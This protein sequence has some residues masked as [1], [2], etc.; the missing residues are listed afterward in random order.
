MKTTK[1]A[2]AA[3]LALMVAGCATQPAHG[4]RPA[5]HDVSWGPGWARIGHAAVH[6]AL[7]PATW[8]PAVGAGLLQIGHADEDV[9]DWASDHTPVFGSRHGAR[10]ASNVFLGSA[11]A[12]DLATTLAQPARNGH[13]TNEQIGRLGVAVG[14][15][16][17]SEGVVQ[18][19]KHG[20]DRERP[21]GSDHDSFP[22]G[23]AAVASTADTMSR[24]NAE[25]LPI[26]WPLRLTIQ[27]AA[28]TLDVA[29][30]YARVAAE[31]HYP[32]DVLA[33][34][35]LGHFVGALASQAFLGDDGAAWAPQVS[36]SRHGGALAWSRTF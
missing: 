10:T 1:P 3:A 23:H 27:G 28:T 13:R 36:L 22:S 16:G 31:K 19:L 2:A 29:T 6:A 30:G 7:S 14:A 4:M 20:I 18:G 26:G 25:T 12:L 8:A 35:A 5:S 33:G 32:S 21:D 15:L 24:Y 9:A 17:V 34:A 11:V